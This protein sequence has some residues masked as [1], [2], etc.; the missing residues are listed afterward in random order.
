MG[1]KLGVGDKRADPEPAVGCVLDRGER[2]FPHVDQMS[3]SLDLELHQIEQI[4]AAGDELRTGRGGDC[5]YGRS[6]A[7]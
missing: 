5:S 7:L 2:Q 1:R 4:G 6:R 3:G